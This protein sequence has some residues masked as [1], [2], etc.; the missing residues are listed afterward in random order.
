MGDKHIKSE[1]L[2]DKVIVIAGGAGLIG[3][4]FVEMVIENA[5]IAIIADINEE[6]SN[7]F[8]YD[9]KSKYGKDSLSAIT[10]DITSKSSIINMIN[11]L[12]KK[13]N[14]IDA[15]INSTY[16]RNENWGRPFEEVEFEDFCANVNMQLGGSFL[17]T[18]ELCLFYKKQ[19]YG[20][21]INISSIQGIMAPKFDTYEG[22]V[23]NGKQ[24]TS[25]AEYAIIKAGIIHLTRYI[26]KYFKGYNIRCNCI[27]SGGIYSGQPE[28]FLK[29]YQ[30]YCLSKGMLNTEDL[31]G[32]LLF[33]LSDMS[34]YVN[35]QN[36]VVDDGWTL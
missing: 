19:G 16:P 34:E 1:L 27:S 21:I 5:G 4:S 15:F 33:L 20:N 17:G 8:L 24:M 30:K 29:N 3:R 31:K 12:V 7:K 10:L 22:A 32:T 18:R 35:G 2:K 11:I 13:Y 26:A 28:I 36:I 23:F 9:C 6:Q 14:K 25:S